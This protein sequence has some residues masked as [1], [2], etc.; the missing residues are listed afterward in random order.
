LY[1]LLFSYYYF[2]PLDS[3]M[4]SPRWGFIMISPTEA[5]FECFLFLYYDFASLDS[6]M[7]S[8]RWGFIMISPRW[9]IFNCT[10]SIGATS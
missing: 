8:P 10:C 7:I 2:A 3:I 4:I 6:I 9:G 5:W 1:V